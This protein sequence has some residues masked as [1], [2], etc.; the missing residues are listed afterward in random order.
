MLKVLYI[1]GDGR[2]GSTL[3]NIALGNHDQVVGMGELC[4]LH[5]FILSRQNWCS[6]GV[7]V[8][9][10][11][12]W[13]SVSSALE[14][15]DPDRVSKLQARYES[16]LATFRWPFWLRTQS[17]QALEYR[18]RLREVLDAVAHVSGASLVV[19]ASKLPGRAMALARMPEV[20]FYL[21]HLVRDAR[22][23]VW[24][25]SKS[26]KQDISGGVEA[27]VPAR[28]T[29]QVCLNWCK[30]NLLTAYV[31]S[32]I[33]AHRSL[34][35]R[36]EDFATNPTKSLNRIG[37]LVGMD[38][39]AIAEQLVAG[40]TLDNGHTGSGNRMRMK[41]VRLAPDFRWTERISQRSEAMTWALTGSILRRYGYE[42]TPRA[43]A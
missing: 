41:N 12:F 19:D 24:A 33:P 36:Y 26:W 37:E 17:T 18:D 13:N 27:D 42:R 8:D 4:N 10:C 16:N 35:I 2:S 15:H 30:A 5:R 7:P 14:H 43:A 40:R 32:H 28:S 11:D 39:S 38:F 6:C 20:D 1:A 22:A 25:R 9:Q 3:L 34:R 29:S 31:R 23:L 21:V